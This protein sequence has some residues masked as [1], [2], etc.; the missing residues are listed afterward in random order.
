MTTDQPFDLKSL[1]KDYVELIARLIIGASVEDLNQN[2]NANRAQTPLTGGWIKEFGLHRKNQFN[3]RLELEMIAQGIALANKNSLRLLADA[4]ILYEAKSYPSAIALAV[5]AIEEMGK[6]MVLNG[7]V[8]LDKG[9]KTSHIWKQYRNH[10]SKNILCKLPQIVEQDGKSVSNIVLALLT[11]DSNHSEELEWLKQFCFYTD[12]VGEGEWQ[13][14]ENISMELAANIIDIA[15]KLCSKLS[16]SVESI[17]LD[18]NKLHAVFSTGTPE[19]QI[20][21]A[22]EYLKDVR[23]S[24]PP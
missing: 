2:R 15:R 23:G 17:L 16:L 13:S 3:G 6:H 21:R 1:P 12:C 9:Q 8:T 10:K 5:L 4:E 14:P 18:I 11:G 22:V 19:E 20:L 7:L 24:L